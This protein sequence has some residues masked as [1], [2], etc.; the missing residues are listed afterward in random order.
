[1][2]W[3]LA[4]KTLNIFSKCNLINILHNYTISI[5][6]KI[7]IILTKT[8]SGV[9]CTVSVVCGALLQWCVVHC[10]SGVWCTVVNY[11]M[12]ARITY[13]FKLTVQ[14]SLSFSHDTARSGPCSFQYN[15]WASLTRNNVPICHIIGF[16][17]LEFIK[18]N[19]IML[20]HSAGAARGEVLHVCY[21]CNYDIQLCK[22]CRFQGS[23][24]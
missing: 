9:W 1:M 13:M 7:K 15:I 19:I 8:C 5:C 21:S 17:E 18:R 2:I 10:C 3:I 11:D 16:A 24:L 22:S 20:G 23:K 14:C 4:G 12:F 6:I